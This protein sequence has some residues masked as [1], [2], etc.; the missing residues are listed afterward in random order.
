MSWLI[1]YST[2]GKIVVSQSWKDG[3]EAPKED[4]GITYVETEKE[5]DPKLFYVSR[6]IVTA[7][8]EFIPETTVSDNKAHI[9]NID[10]GS[11]L[12]VGNETVKVDDN[13]GLEIEFEEC[14]KYII[15]IIDSPA[16]LD[17][18]WEVSID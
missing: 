16:Y 14:G 6:E 10:K 18:T 11:L 5:V 13:N 1:G 8:T 15:E 17:K 9:K 2:T 4:K 12:L 3:K 7:K